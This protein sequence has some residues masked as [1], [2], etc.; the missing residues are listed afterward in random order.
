MVIISNPCITQEF[1]VSVGGSLYVAEGML[2]NGI[3]QATSVYLLD[4]KF[5]EARF[6]DERRFRV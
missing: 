3:A 1:A 6:S 5:S 2:E 4:F